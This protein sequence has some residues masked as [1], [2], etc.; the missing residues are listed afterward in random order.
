VNIGLANIGLGESLIDIGLVNYSESTSFQVGFINATK[1]LDGLQV[2][3]INY[4]ENGV[5]PVLPI[6]NFKKGL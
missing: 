1:K 2:G 3:L 6:I 5:V 4:A